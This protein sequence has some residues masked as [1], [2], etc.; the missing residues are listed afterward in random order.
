MYTDQE[1]HTTNLASS[2]FEKSLLDAF[3]MNSS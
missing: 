2:S 3:K 1:H